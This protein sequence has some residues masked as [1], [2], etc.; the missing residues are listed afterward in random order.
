MTQPT[1][2]LIEIDNPLM[3]RRFVSG[4]VSASTVIFISL[5]LYLY[6]PFA[7]RIT[8]SILFNISMIGC[9]AN[10]QVV[11]LSTTSLINNNDILKIVYGLVTTY[12]FFFILPGGFALMAWRTGQRVRLYLK[13]FDPPMDKT[14]EGAEAQ[15]ASRGLREFIAVSRWFSCGKEPQAVQE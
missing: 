9:G 6:F 10:S 15:R 5:A 8:E 12:L 7:M 14:T 4:V 13:S 1:H 3:A 11:E 2:T